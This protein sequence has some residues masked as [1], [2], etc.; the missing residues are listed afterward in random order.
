MSSIA[1]TPRSSSSQ[2]RSFTSGEG[3]N[4]VEM[5][6]LSSTVLNSGG[7]PVVQ[8]LSQVL[9][10]DPSLDPA[11][12]DDD[13]SVYS[14]DR[15]TF[16]SSACNV[17]SSH[18]EALSQLR[19]ENSDLKAQLKMISDEMAELRLEHAEALSQLRK[20]NSDLKAQLKMIG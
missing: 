3:V 5:P 17:D 8:Q 13:T 16:L 6:A 12:E 1:M 20:E 19:K 2:K 7:K 15:G 18:A 9:E 14:T 11:E 10:D 4:T